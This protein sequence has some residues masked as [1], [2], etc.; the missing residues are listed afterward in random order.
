MDGVATAGLCYLIEVVIIEAAEMVALPSNSAYRLPATR[1]IPSRSTLSAFCDPPSSALSSSETADISFV[2]VTWS[3]WR[4]R[5]TPSCA[6]RSA[7]IHCSCTGLTR[8]TTIA[9]LRKLSIS[10]MV[11]YPAMETTR[12]AVDTAHHV[13]VELLDHQARMGRGEADA[14]PILLG[15]FRPADQQRLDLRP[16][17]EMTESV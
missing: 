6:R 4:A 11:L 3:G 7:R 16:R 1:D 9:R 8:G 14:A 5:S 12:S 15:H 10:Q 13:V 17:G 2:G